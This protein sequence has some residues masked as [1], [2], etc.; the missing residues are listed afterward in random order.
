MAPA[1]DTNIRDRAIG[2]RRKLIYVVAKALREN[3]EKYNIREA[4]I[5]GSLLQSHRWDQFSDVDVAV[6]GCSQHILSIMRDVEEVTDKD[7][8]VIDLDNHTTPDWVRKK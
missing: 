3:R 5:T 1:F 7:V 2:E 6:A 4:Y 8:D